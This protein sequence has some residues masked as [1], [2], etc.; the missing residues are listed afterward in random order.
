MALQDLIVNQKQISEDLLEKILKGKVELVKETYGVNLIR[1]SQRLS[2]KTKILL[3]LCGKKAWELIEGKKFDVS[4]NELE[5]LGINSS[6]IR[7]TLKELKDENMACSDKDHKY[8]ILPKGIYFLEELSSKH[9]LPNTAKI[10][11]SAKKKSVRRGV[12]GRSDVIQKL[13]EINK[14][15]QNFIEK[16]LS[17]FGRINHQEKYL[18]AIYVATEELKL[19]GLTPSEINFVL[20]EPPIRLQKFHVSNI[21]R[22]LGKLKIVIP[23]PAGKGF[24]YRLT[25]EGLQTAK[26][27]LEESNQKNHG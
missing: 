6:S 27:L 4:I 24:E 14:L 17:I 12:S 13:E 3:F 15:P 18:L 9:E 25:T 21:S 10:Q 7:G 5:L 1:E 16:I 8:S 2:N 23:Y 20:T 19:T 22:D 26:R 11:T